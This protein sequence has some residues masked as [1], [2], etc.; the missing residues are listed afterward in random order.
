MVRIR[1]PSFL[2]SCGCNVDY[3]PSVE[4][5]FHFC[6]NPY[7]GNGVGKIIHHAAGEV[8]GAMLQGHRPQTEKILHVS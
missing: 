2:P 5:S 3:L 6:S 8:P 4:E 1:F 7:A